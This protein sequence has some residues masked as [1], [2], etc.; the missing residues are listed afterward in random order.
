MITRDITG[1]K[2]DTIEEVNAA[3]DALCL[4]LGIP[5]DG[6]SVMTNAIKGI[7][8]CDENDEILY[9]FVY[10]NPLFVPILGEPITFEINIGK[11]P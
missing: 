4:A 3:D 1:Y 5:K 10:E 11:T 2:W 7:I 6:S 8:N 9:Y